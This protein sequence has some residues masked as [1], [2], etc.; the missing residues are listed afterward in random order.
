MLERV[1][2]ERVL[3]CV[4]VLLEHKADVNLTVLAFD[5]LADS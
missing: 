1:P 4:K 3:E 5:F 2:V